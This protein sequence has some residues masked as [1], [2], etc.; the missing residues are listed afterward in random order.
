MTETQFKTLKPFDE[1]LSRTGLVVFLGVV[2]GKVQ[3]CYQSGAA[4]PDS[5]EVEIFIRDFEIPREIY[6]Q[7][8]PKGNQKGWYLSTY[9]VVIKSTGQESEYF[10][11]YCNCFRTQKHGEHYKKIVTSPEYAEYIRERMQEM[12]DSESDG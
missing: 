1:V 8:I 9:G 10:S 6:T 2:N 4:V 11:K 7:Y 3:L 5:Y 12:I